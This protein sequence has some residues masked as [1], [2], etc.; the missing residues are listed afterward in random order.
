MRLIVATNN[1]HKL[2]EFATIF[3]EHA[4]LSP[5]SFGLQFTHD[6]T[7]ATFA[8][9]SLGKAISLYR[10]LQQAGKID[11]NLVVIADDSGLCVDALGGRPGLHSARYGAVE[12]AP[13]LSDSQRNELLLQEMAGKPT[14]TAHFVCCMVA[15]YAPNR[16]DCIQETWEGEISAAASNSIAGFGY[17]PVMYIPALGKTVAQLAPEDKAR[18]SHRGKA[19]SRL[20]I[21]L[22]R[23]T[24]S[25]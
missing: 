16:F 21:L 12:G 11:D 23:S 8:E 25:C 17:D 14:R 19:C 20:K 22:D 4:I 9:N 24:S 5:A 2:E 6:E 7:G 15:L 3:T 13:A 10:L 18:L 1:A